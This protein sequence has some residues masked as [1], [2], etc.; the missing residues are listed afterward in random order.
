MTKYLGFQYIA[1]VWQLLYFSTGQRSCPQGAWDRAAVNLWNT[2]L[3][4]SSSV[5]SQQSWLEPGRLPDV[6]EASQPDAWRS[7]GSHTWSKSGN[8]STRCSSLKPS[9]S[10]VH[11]FELA[12]EDTEDIL[13]TDF[14]YVW[15]LYRRTLW[16]V[17]AGAYSGHFCLGWP[18]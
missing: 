12:F 18:H 1:T 11:V 15:Y 14:S 8:I 6:G 7:P 2:R 9:G 16:Q 17:C 5:A 4:C 3:H 10:G 13:N